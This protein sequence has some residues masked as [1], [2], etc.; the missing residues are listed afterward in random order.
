[1]LPEAGT[2]V[3]LVTL[4]L[5]VAVTENGTVVPFGAVAFTT[6][7]AGHV[8]TGGMVSCTC[9]DWFS[10]LW[11]PTTSVNVHPTVKSPCPKLE[12]EVVIPVICPLQ[13]SVA[14]GAVG[15]TAE[16]SP[17]TRVRLA[18]FGTGPLQS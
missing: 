9:I 15:S 1:M 3:R 5:C 18:T 7:F 6:M 2:E 8:I 13:L 14:F 16:H 10:E 17:T 4:Q 11:L 12:G